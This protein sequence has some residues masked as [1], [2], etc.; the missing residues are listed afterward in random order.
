MSAP[1]HRNPDPE[2]MRRLRLGD[3]KRLLRHRYGPTLPDDD[4]GREDLRELLLPVS[5]RVDSPVLV[6]RNII[7]TWAPWMDAAETYSI[8]QE[9][10]QTPPSVRTR[11]AKNLGGRLNVTNDERERLRLWTIAPVDLTDHQRAEWR[12]AKRNERRTQKRRRAGIKSRTAFL[13]SSKSRQKP[14]ESQGV[15]RRTWYRRRK[16][17]AQ[18]VAQVVAQLNSYQY[19]DETCATEQDESQQAESEKKVAKGG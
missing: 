1:R 16:K 6:M 13:A 2:V 8:L 7:E 18:S 5:L 9:I 15:S 14:W 4:A 3:L 10:E 17:L 11:T 19:R 12:R